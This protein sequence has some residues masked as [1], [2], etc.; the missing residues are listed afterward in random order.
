[1]NGN[2]RKE[3]DSL[4]IKPNWEA[5]I[6]GAQELKHAYHEQIEI[7]LF[8]E[9][10]T[11]IIVEEEIFIV[12]PGDLLVIN[13][14]EFHTTVKLEKDPCR[15]HLLMID[16]DFFASHGF[17]E[18][19]LYKIFIGDRTRFC[20]QIRNNVRLNEIIRNIVAEFCDKR[21]GYRIVIEGLFMEFFTLLLRDY[22]D[23]CGGEKYTI[24][25]ESLYKKI[26]P[27][28]SQMV[29]DFSHHFTLEE[30]AGLCCLS[31]YH[32]CR[33]F[34]QVTDMTPLQYLT[35]YRLKYA[36]VLMARTDYTITE[37]AECC[38]FGDVAY[39]S[40]VYKKYRGVPP[41]I[42]SAKN[43]QSTENI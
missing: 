37:V 36:E 20:N 18:I 25:N 35:E 34:K 40:R 11:T 12:Q 7:K 8:L 29:R 32:F 2:G 27:A 16:L 13:P 41:K 19:D 15:Y 21:E 28:I 17:S 10:T 24:R 9:G 43:Y 6:S 5:F 23:M 4:H 31:K 22:Q 42:Y 14:Y 38:G 33:T 3:K 1:M 39:F 30:L 26:E